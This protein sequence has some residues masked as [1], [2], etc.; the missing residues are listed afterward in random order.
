MALHSTTLMRRA[1]R[2]VVTALAATLT[3]TLILASSPDLRRHASGIASSPG[4]YRVG[5]SIDVP[6]RYYTGK[7]KTVI[8][9]ARHNC[10]ACKSAAPMIRDLI[11]HARESAGTS[12]VFLA[13]TNDALEE[14]AFAA[15][16]GIPAL[17]VAVASEWY[18][19]SARLRAVPTVVVVDRAG[20]IQFVH[21]GAAEPDGT[22]ETF[23]RFVSVLA[24]HTS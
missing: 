9:F 2:F 22:R 15:S 23:D 6:A 24:Q 19:S 18:S 14:Q 12:T 3:A 8:I 4:G 7:E 16:I 10:P 11:I 17:G 20:I 1:V 5:A 13:T 21:V